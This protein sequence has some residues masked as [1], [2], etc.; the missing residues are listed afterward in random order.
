MVQQP[1]I[2]FLLDSNVSNSISTCLLSHGHVVLRANDYLMP[3]ASDRL[4]VA[5]A[6]QLDAVVVTFNKKHF[7]PLIHRDDARTLAEFPNAGLLV[8]QSSPVHGIALLNRWIPHIEFAYDMQRQQS[9]D[10]RFIA[11]LS[12]T[13]LL[14]R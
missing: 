10:R 12:M 13:G 4:V 7:R 3:G 2:R 1:H 6:D 14:L 11:E 5:L 9:S 8:L